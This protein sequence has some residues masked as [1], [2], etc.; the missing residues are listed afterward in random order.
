MTLRGSVLGRH[1]ARRAV[2]AVELAILLPVICFLLI[3]TVDYARVFYYSLT[4]TNCARNGAVYESDAAAKG[5]SSYA[6]T[7]AAALA[8]AS[9]LSPAP[10]VT[11]ST[12]GDVVSVTVTYPFETIA[13]YPGVP[14]TILLTRTVQMRMLPSTPDM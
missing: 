6:T 7:Q 14:N 2:A 3:I 10:T 5:E 12:S 13:N 4:I 1:G 11:S 8:D 9:N